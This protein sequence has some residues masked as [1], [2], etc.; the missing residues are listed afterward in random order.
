MR[1][2]CG[3]TERLRGARRELHR[4]RVR[5]RQGIHQRLIE[6]LLLALP[7]FTLVAVLILAAPTA[8][9]LHA[10]SYGFGC[11]LCERVGHAGLS[12]R[13]VA[14]SDRSPRIRYRA[15]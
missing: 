4:E 3:P 12:A 9:A 14:I 15:S 10:Q 5:G 2:T 6:R 13:L 1:H 7:A 11:A 8:F